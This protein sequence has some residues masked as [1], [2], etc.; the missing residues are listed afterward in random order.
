MDMKVAQKAL[1]RAKIKLMSSPDTTFFTTVCFSLKHT[2]TTEM[3]TA[4][5]N[6][7]ELLINPDFFMSLNED[8]RVSLLLHEVGHVIFLHCTTRKGNRNPQKWNVAGDYVINLMLR[9][10]GFTI[11]DTWLIDNIYADKS[12]EEVYDLLPEDAAAKLSM[13]D[14]MPG[15][16]SP[17]KAKEQEQAITDILIRAATQSKLAGDKP[18]SV[19]GEVEIYL[20]R[21]LNPKLP[22]QTILSRFLN[23][24][25]KDDYSWQKP[26]KRYFPDMYLPS[27]Y[28]EGLEH[29]AFAVDTSGSVSTADF[30]SFISEIRGVMKHFNP[31]KITLIQFDTRIKSTHTIHSME[32]LMK[33]KFC[34]RGGT[35]ITEVME[36]AEKEMPQAL[37]VFTDGEFHQTSHK[38]KS[39][40]IWLI[41]NNKRFAGKQGKTIHYTLEA[42]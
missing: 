22:W 27:L 19:P 1:D 11:P 5:T 12:T 26:N 41:H 25:V 33:V 36:W 39:P 3:P 9:N 21:M 6:G 24:H 7:L 2:W 14:I 16:E 30:S 28:S 29:I 34:G 8:T 18:G 37:L 32:E 20:D 31:E 4:G 35:D 23:D 10:R 15:D 17:E 40:L 38:I 13:P 42:A